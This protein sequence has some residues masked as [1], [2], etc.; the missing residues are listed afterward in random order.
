MHF[1]SWQ[2]TD[3]EAVEIFFFLVYAIQLALNH[4]GAKNLKIEGQRGAAKAR[5]QGRGNN[6]FRVGQMPTFI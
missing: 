4:D 5:T 1:C 6:F 2:R 3:D